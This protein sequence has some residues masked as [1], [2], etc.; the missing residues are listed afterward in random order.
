MQNSKKRN[1]SYFPGISLESILRRYSDRQPKWR[2]IVV[3]RIKHFKHTQVA[4]SLNDHLRLRLPEETPDQQMRTYRLLA[5]LLRG[6]GH[7]ADAE[8]IW[9]VVP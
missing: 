3:V 4:N 6:R 5:T 8:N 9:R 2:D 1:R 7:F